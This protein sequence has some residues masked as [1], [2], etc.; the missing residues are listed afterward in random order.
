MI[1]ARL[2]SCLVHSWCRRD[3]DAVHWSNKLFEWQ[4]YWIP[5]LYSPTCLARCTTEQADDDDERPNYD[6]GYVNVQSWLSDSK[7]QMQRHS[8]SEYLLALL[9]CRDQRPL[10][11]AKA[12]W[13]QFARNFLL[14]APKHVT[15]FEHGTVEIAKKDACLEESCERYGLI[16]NILVLFCRERL[17][18]CQSTIGPSNYIK[19]HTQETVKLNVFWADHQ[20][21]F[22]S[23][24]EIKV[25]VVIA[26]EFLREWKNWPR[27]SLINKPKRF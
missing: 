18:H 7:T 27:R 1:R 8:T 2:S 13:R 26:A 3:V 6:F 23:V 25:V 21:V 12:H 10:L 22:L 16:E 24:W 5:N 11:H 20:Q 4:I 17:G 19:Y 9:A 14:R 15:K